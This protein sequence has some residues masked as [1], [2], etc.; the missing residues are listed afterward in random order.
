MKFS[1][2]NATLLT[3]LLCF[4][5]SAI[6]QQKGGIIFPKTKRAKRISLSLNYGLH[7]ITA[8]AA[9]LSLKYTDESPAPDVLSQQVA[10]EQS[11]GARGLSGGIEWQSKRSLMYRFHFGGGRNG[12]KQTR[13]NY[14]DFGFGYA[15]GNRRAQFYPM[16]D[17]I[18]S[19]AVIEFGN[20]QNTT[21]YVEINGTQ[22]NHETIKTNLVVSFA[23]WRPSFGAHL[24]LTKRIG[25]QGN[26][27]WLMSKASKNVSLN[28]SASDA[29][30]NETTASEDLD[31]PN[32]ELLY[33]GNRTTVLPEVFKGR[34]FAWN[35]GVTFGINRMFLKD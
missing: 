16:V 35:V 25:L 8:S 20:F 10:V 9:N 21:G 17:L 31:Q 29:N 18:L 32:V 1:F 14:F 13:A 33:N 19:N 24:V 23:G 11:D 15:M 30:G 7:P 5:A 22:F 27:G 3:I 34:G 26:I 12:A 2:K 4:S 6:A 28:F